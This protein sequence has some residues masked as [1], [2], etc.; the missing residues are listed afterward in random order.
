MIKHRTF[1]SKQIQPTSLF[2]PENKLHPHHDFSNFMHN[3]RSILHDL[4][5]MVLLSNNHF[6][7][8]LNIEKRFFMFALS[9]G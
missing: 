3:R 2:F 7:V 1:W 6:Q 9:G 8:T 4:T 5:S